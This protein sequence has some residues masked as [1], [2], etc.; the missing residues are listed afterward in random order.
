MTFM[1]WQNR[2][3][4]MFLGLALLSLAPMSHAADD[5][6]MQETVERVARLFS[7][8]VQ[9]RYGENADHQ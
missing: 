6:Q 8:Q 1:R 2:S 7:Q 3:V 5:Q 9:H 4:A